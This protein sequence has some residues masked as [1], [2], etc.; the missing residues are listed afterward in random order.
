MSVLETTIGWLAPPDCIA[1]GDEGNLLCKQCSQ[2]KIKPFGER[3]WRCNTISIGSRTCIKCRS[4][5]PLASVY[6]CTS[7]EDTAQAIIRAYKFGHSRVGAEPLA[8]LMSET[9][10]KYSNSEAPLNDYLIIP[11]PTATSRTRDRGFDHSQLLSKTIAVKL[12]LQY[13]NSLRRIDQIRQLGSSRDDRLTQLAN[14][15]V[16]KGRKDIIGRKVL[17]IDDVLTTGGTLISA[18]RI[19]KLAGAKQ[20]DAIVFAKK[21]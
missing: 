12:H 20:V 9:F 8:R 14:S 15:F 2:N 7:Y 21:L 1:C 19:L 10:L 18:A 4:V 6:I 3:C 11:I 17:L 16:V 5:G 13:S